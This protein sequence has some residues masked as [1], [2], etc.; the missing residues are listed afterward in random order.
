MMKKL[1]LISSVIVLIGLGL[2]QQLRLNSLEQ[3][4][5]TWQARAMALQ[6]AHLGDSLIRAGNW[7]AAREMYQNTGFTIRENWLARV[8]AA[9]RADADRISKESALLNRLNEQTEQLAVSQKTAEDLQE[10][11]AILRYNMR[12]LRDS[13]HGHAKEM[14]HLAQQHDSLWQEKEA[15]QAQLSEQLQRFN[16]ELQNKAM[17]RFKSPTGVDI[18][19]FGQTLD[20]K[21]HGRGTGFY[22]NGTNYEGEWVSGE[23]HGEGIYIYPNNER[24]EGTFMYNKRNGFGIYTWPNGDTYRGYWK[25]DKREGEGTIK[26]A[27][28]QVLRS[29][30]WQNDKLAEGRAVDLK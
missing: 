11:I 30:L 23:K 3:D 15:V 28:G 16:T 26:N 24:F 9:E 4:V 27:K 8:D 2:K 12:L 1:R 18:V 20:G 7:A 25:D 22:S 14:L 6:G 17:L 13:A 21:P 29:G 5:E 10:Q 19:Y